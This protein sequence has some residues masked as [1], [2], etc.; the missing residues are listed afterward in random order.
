MPAKTA[1]DLVVQF[2]HRGT[3]PDASGYPHYGTLQ[4]ANER[5]QANYERLLNQRRNERKALLSGA[6]TP[7]RR[8]KWKARVAAV[9]E[10]FA[11]CLGLCVSTVKPQP[12]ALTFLRA[13]IIGALGHILPEFDAHLSGLYYRLPSAGWDGSDIEVLILRSKASSAPRPG[14]LLIPDSGAALVG[15]ESPETAAAQ[16]GCA[17]AAAGFLVAI[18][19]LP[20]MQRLSSTHN[21]RRLLEG[22][23]ALGEIVG[24]AARALDGLLAQPDID[25]QVAWSA[26]RGLGGVAAQFLGLLDGRVAGILSDSPLSWGNVRDA[27]ALIIP[28]Q[29]PVTDEFELCAALAPRAFALVAGEAKQDLFSAPAADTRALARAAQPA[30]AMLR[31]PDRLASF[32]QSNPKAAIAWMLERSSNFGDIEPL[33]GRA[34]RGVFPRRHFSVQQ[35]TSMSEWNVDRKRLRREYKEKCGIPAVHRPLLVREEGEWSLPHY[36]RQEYQIKTSDETFS[37]VVFMRPPGGVRRRPTILYLPGSGSDV[38]R[39]EREFA[40]EV[41]DEGWNACIIDARAALYPF[42]PGIAEGRA[43]ISQSLHDLLCCLEWVVER[44]DVDTDRIGTMGVSQGGTHSWMLAAMDDRIAAAAPVCGLCTYKSLIDNHVNEW[45]GGSFN[46]FLDSHSIYYY[47][48]GVLELAE[49]QDLA[50]LIAPRPLLVL[51]ATHD[52]C[53]PLDGMRDAAADLRYLY[54]LAGAESNFEYVEFDGPHSMPGHSRKT[55]YAFFH[56]HFK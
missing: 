36:T 30:Y 40:H 10:T 9:R 32:S 13:T 54:S 47:T 49:Q 12:P 15:G 18:P 55:A 3:P 20:A 17:L 31:T 33:P 7:Q 28:R 46:S 43:I 22:S 21:K 52:D 48:P 6:N 34:V 42:H 25:G 16:W 45:Y 50:A 4:F 38:A 41:I 53:F 37:N 29:R 39:V 26:G 56:R 14:V 5:W 27:H 11:Q 23:C 1:R 8:A 2:P 51:G 35:Y 19:R 24:E 44:S